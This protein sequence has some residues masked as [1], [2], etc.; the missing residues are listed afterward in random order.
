MPQR[1]FVNPVKTTAYPLADVGIVMAWARRSVYSAIAKRLKRE[2]GTRVHL[3]VSSETEAQGFRDRED[4]SLWSSVT[5]W[6]VLSERITDAGLDEA[7]VVARARDFEARLG[8]TTNRLTF[9]H[10]Q[11]S[12]GHSP[13]SYHYPR[14]AHFERASYLQLLHGYNE[15]VAFWENQI[16]DKGLRLIIDGDKLVSATTRMMGV[17]FRRMIGSRYKNY[18]FWTLDEYQSN[19]AIVPIFQ[20][21][22]EWDAAEL[23]EGYPTSTSR[24]ST[25]HR[26]VGLLKIMRRSALAAAQ[27]LWWMWRGYERVRN[28]NFWN[29]VLMPLREVWRYRQTRRV[30][31]AKIS[32]LGDTQFAYFPLHKEPETSFLTRSP[33]FTNQ[34]AAIMAVARDLPAGVRLVVKENLLSIGTRPS[35]FLPQ[36]ADMQNVILLDVHESGIEA[37]RRCTFVATITGT[38]GLEAAGLGKPVLTFTPHVSYGFLDHVRV[39]NGVDDLRPAITWALSFTDQDE[40]ASRQDGARF[41]EALKQASFDMGDYGAAI[42]VKKFDEVSEDTVKMVFDALLE[43]LV[44]LTFEQPAVQNQA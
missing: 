26:R 18:W 1:R 12:R 15:S 35:S 8:E 27:Y 29:I 25:Y 30:A 28:F 33:N 9:S 31:K 41:F 38:A 37:I 10:R 42:G 36:L 40:N 3:Y 4:G 20:L 19:P 17:P 6:N 7:A 24:S 2:L 5:C 44:E 16:T 13:G 43:S 11:F 39:V 22:K 34:H 14:A 32:D 23:T 21:L